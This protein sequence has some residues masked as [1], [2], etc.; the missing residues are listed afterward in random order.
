M[1]DY[2]P[3]EILVYALIFIISMIILNALTGCAAPRVWVKPSTCQK[4]HG[5]DLADC[6]K[7]GDI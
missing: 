3:F 1:D 6:E 7:I 2:E 4:L 5:L